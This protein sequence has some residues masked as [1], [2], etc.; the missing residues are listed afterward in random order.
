MPTRRTI[1]AGLALTTG[2]AFAR[3]L[4]ALDLTDAQVARD[5]MRPQYHLQPARGWMNDPCG[6]IYWRGRYHMF[7]QY[8]PHAAI[9]GDMHWAHATSPDMVHWH[10]EPIAL[11]PTPGG[12]DQD[13]CFTGTAV[14]AEGKPT[15]LY[16]G[17][18]KVPSDQ[19][20]LRDGNSN[21]RE[22]QCLAV[23]EDDALLHWR[24]Q[25][26]PVIAAPPAGMEITGFR[27][28]APW[29]NE[30][31][32]QWY[33]IVASGLRGVGGNVLLYKSADLRHWQYLYPLAQGKWSGKPGANPVDT[34]EMWECPDFFPL[35]DQQDGKHVLIHSTEGRTI[36]QIGTLQNGKTDRATMLFHAESEGLLDHG[37]YYAPKTQLD[38]HG[39]RILWGWIQETRP[40]AE[41]SVAGWAGMMSLPRRLSIANGQ[42]VMGPAP[43]IESLRTAPRTGSAVKRLPSAAQEIR[44][45]LQPARSGSAFEQ[46]FVD[47]QGAVILLRADP[48]QSVGTARVGEKEIAGIAPGPIDLHIF[49]DHSVAEI[50]INHRQVITQRYYRRTPMEPAVAITLGGKL[51]I[52]QQ[53]AWSLKSVW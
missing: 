31:D 15:F 39:N 28:P 11:A 41:Y 20:T 23:A 49:L 12:P 36:W 21:L 45:T 16:T 29:R 1:L 44:L 37:G 26:Q 38:A 30:Q 27:D 52:A 19:A 22:T 10:R 24:K 9:W 53:Q 35:G 34:G 2:A 5:P 40:Q 18:R 17:V 13:G 14:V 47:N 46:S 50:F 4:P 7:F 6:P 42:L 33:T 51:G 32:G 25:S 48:Q 43:E 8:N 3:K